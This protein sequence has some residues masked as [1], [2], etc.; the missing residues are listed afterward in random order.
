MRQI[1]VRLVGSVSFLSARF[2]ASGLQ[3]GLQIG[4]LTCGFPSLSILLVAAIPRAVADVFRLAQ[5]AS[6]E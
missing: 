3:I 4:L 2:T 5:R 6:G 1:T